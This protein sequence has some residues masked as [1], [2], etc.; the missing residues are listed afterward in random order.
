MAARY[1]PGEDPIGRRVRVRDGAWTTIV[2]VSGDIIQDWFD[3]RNAPT[4]YRPIAQFPV[5]FMGL[6]VRTSGDPAAVAGAV[7]QALLRVDPAQPI[8]EMMP[9]RQQLHERTIGLQYLAA[10][11]TVFGGLALI[12]AAV[13]LYAVTAYLVTQRRHEI[14]LRIA[15]GASARDVVRMTVGQALRLTLVGAAI[16]LVLSVALSRLMEAGILGIATSDVRVFL[17]FAAVLI[18]SAMLAGYLPAR[19]AATIDPMIALRAQ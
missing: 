6:V 17:A 3:K 15:L 14:G 10:I 4:L 8:F 9:M 1:W 2:G 19:R 18:A 5:D 11:M 7:R 12:L 13:G 16:G